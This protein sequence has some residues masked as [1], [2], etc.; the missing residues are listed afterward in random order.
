MR[1]FGNHLGVCF[2]V[3]VLDGTNPAAKAAWLT[4]LTP[5]WPVV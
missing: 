3:T 4:P 5:E 1:A 2:L